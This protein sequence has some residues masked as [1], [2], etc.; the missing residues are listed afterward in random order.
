MK[1]IPRYL[2]L[3]GR[4]EAPESAWENATG[5][6]LAAEYGALVREFWKDR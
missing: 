6:S 4:G 5:K 2:G 3:V 1:K